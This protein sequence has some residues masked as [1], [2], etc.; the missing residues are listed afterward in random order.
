MTDRLPKRENRVNRSVDAGVAKPLLVTE[1]AAQIA[2]MRWAFLVLAVV[3]AALSAQTDFAACLKSI[4]ATQPGQRLRADTWERYVQTLQPDTRVITQQQA[5]PEFTLPIWDYVAVMVDDER[6]AD[7]RRLMS[8]HAE[9]LDAIE[10]RY[11]VDPAVVVAIWGIESNFGRGT[12]SFEVLRS[13][14][15]LACHGRRQSYF[16]GELLAAMR[17]VQK[18]DIDG[19]RFLGS[20]AGAFGQVQ[21]MPGSYEWLAVDFDG[22]G[23][24]DILHNEGDALASAANFL[25]Q[26]GW[27]HGSPWGVEVRLPDEFRTRGEGRRVQRT[28]STWE[29]RGLRRVDGSRLVSPDLPSTTRAGLH[30]PAGPAGPAFLVL[31]NFNVIY[32][33][34]ASEA[35]TLAIAHLADRLRGGAPF[36]TAW[37]TDDPGLSRAERREL[38]SLLAARGHDV[39]APSGV[40]TPGTRDAVKK[41]QE[42]L[43]HDVTGR[44]GQ[45]LLRAL[46]ERTFPLT[47]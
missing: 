40:L 19:D 26:R 23:R 41:E 2:L 15:T 11:R 34:N 12:G 29:A 36:G 14:A 47:P 22:D 6:I 32:R 20:W 44:P 38:Q 33:Y 24:R 30:L 46:R 8:E 5:Q 4:R 13:L 39:G 1:V 43:G 37:P 42:R 27:R 21:F 31:H 7:G 45:R 35:Y 28:I 3:P 17:A 9:T 18:G 10:L 16:R 25:R